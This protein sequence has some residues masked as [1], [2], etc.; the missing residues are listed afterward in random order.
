MRGLEPIT[1]DDVDAAADDARI[2]RDNFC[3]WA[4]R[5]RDG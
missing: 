2:P 3:R 5:Y 1:P 4:S